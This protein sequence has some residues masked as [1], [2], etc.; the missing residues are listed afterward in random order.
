MVCAGT[1][2]AWGEGSYCI[3]ESVCNSHSF[4]SIISFQSSGEKMEH[5]PNLTLRSWVI[6]FP[7]VFEFIC[8]C[9]SAWY[10]HSPCLV[11]V[12]RLAMQIIEQCMWD[13]KKKKVK[14]RWDQTDLGVGN[15]KSL[16]AGI[17]P[18]FCLPVLQVQGKSSKNIFF[19][20]MAGKVVLPPR[21]MNLTPRVALL[22]IWCPVDRRDIH[23]C[24]FIVLPWFHSISSTRRKKK[25]KEFRLMDESSMSVSL[26]PQLV[27]WGACRLW[28]E[29]CIRKSF[30][31]VLL[32]PEI[33]ISQWSREKGRKIIWET[34]DWWWNHLIL[35]EINSRKSPHDYSRGKRV[36]SNSLLQES[37]VSLQL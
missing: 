22:C 24:N 6:L 34:A 27:V 28:D 1:R 25:K 2:W 19:W 36:L 30:P 15:V 32:D 11:V 26:G 10:P 16:F 23:A 5:A 37:S 8:M 35:M 7:Y 9:L 29:V 17:Y 18:P 14:E 12:M 13:G 4:P 21:M 20:K 31:F 33:R 3:A